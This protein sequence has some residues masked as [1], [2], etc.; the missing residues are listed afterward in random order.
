MKKIHSSNVEYLFFIFI[1]IFFSLVRP[2][3]Q[4]AL[5]G[6]LVLSGK[7]LYPDGIN[8]MKYYYYN[9]WTFLHQI[10]AV[11]IKLNFSNALISRIIIFFSTFFFVVGIYLI[12][13]IITNNKIFSIFLSLFIVIFKKNFGA[14]EYGT[15]MF[16]IHTY[17]MISLALTTL[18]LGTNALKN[19][20]LS[21]F[22][23]FLLIT[24]HPVV[25]SWIFL[26][27]VISLIIYNYFEEKKLSFKEIKLGFFWGIIVLG[28]SLFIFN[29]YY[30]Q[31]IDSNYLSNFDV[32]LKYWDIHRDI[33]AQTNFK[34]FFKTLI[35][36][37]L[38]FYFF[39]EAKKKNKRIEYFIYFITINILASVLI[40]ITYKQFYYL[41]PKFFLQVMPARFVILYSV[42]GWP[43]I[44]SIIYLLYKKIIKS[45]EFKYEFFFLLLI[46]IILS[47]SEMIKKDFNSFKNLLTNNIQSDDKSFWYQVSNKNDL[48]VLTTS[49]IVYD[50][51]R[52]GFKPIILDTSSFDFIPYHPHTV[53]LLKEIIEQIYDVPFD[54]PPIKSFAYLPDEVIK[55]NF[56]K[57]TKLEWYKISK[58]FEF[59]SIIVP[60]NWKISLS[61]V[62]ESKNYS[63]YIL[64]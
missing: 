41:L 48:M 33:S 22:F 15:A 53:N 47:R 54:K 12:T 52:K 2:Y 20:N 56:Q 60:S 51:T 18:I 26:M 43:I 39:Y 31:P 32:Y 28:S 19:L 3:E 46:F 35:L 50:V 27:H 59:N 36:I 5:D 6:G 16:S 37:I 58:K 30:L 23:S 44:I 55:L 64:Y 29:I 62:L 14:V 38:I 42:V 49:S 11:L 9:S 57:K 4:V 7:I 17:G 63:L 1:S 61:P 40:Y 8:I 10:I 13:K 21:I 45:H 24:I 34:Y 25:G